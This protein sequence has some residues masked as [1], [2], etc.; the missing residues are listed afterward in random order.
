MQ[1]IQSSRIDALPLHQRIEDRHFTPGLR[2]A[3]QI[4]PDINRPIGW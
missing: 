1:K 4:C 2:Q 3:L